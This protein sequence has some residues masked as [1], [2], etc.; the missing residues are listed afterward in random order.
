[1]ENP[2]EF[3]AVSADSYPVAIYLFLACEKIGIRLRRARTSCEGT[4]EK[5]SFVP[6]FSAY[7]R[8]RL[9]H[10]TVSA[11]ARSYIKKIMDWEQSIN[12]LEDEHAVLLISVSSFLQKT[13]YQTQYRVRNI[14]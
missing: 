14:N 3:P 9:P 4:K 8:P 13:A 7:L 12:K 2:L 11:R 5:F 6:S 1:M 10:V